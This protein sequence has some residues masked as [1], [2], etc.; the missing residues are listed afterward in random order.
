LAAHCIE[1]LAADQDAVGAEHAGQQVADLV[2]L[3][4]VVPLA[5]AGRRQ[6]LG[7][8]GP[9]GPPAAG[10]AVAYELLFLDKEY[11]GVFEPAKAQPW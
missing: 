8:A 1:P 5:E 9:A 7:E 3:G 4:Q 6:P 10:R 11:S 2:E